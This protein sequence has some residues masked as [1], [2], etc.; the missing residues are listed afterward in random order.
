MSAPFF[1]HGLFGDST[2]LVVALGIG[3]AFGWFLERSAYL[4]LCARS[5]DETRELEPELFAVLARHT[6]EMARYPDLL[7]EAVSL[8]RA[9]DE[10]GDDLD[11][12]PEAPLAADFG[13]ELVP[14]DEGQ[15]IAT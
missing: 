14:E 2:S 5:E 4:W 3:I 9:P 1:E 11:D 13:E 6:G 8:C 15:E 10:L 7:R 12:L